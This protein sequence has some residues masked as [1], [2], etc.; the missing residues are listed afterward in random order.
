MTELTVCTVRLV[1]LYGMD[2]LLVGLS[3]IPTVAQI[4]ALYMCTFTVLSKVHTG[5]R[6]SNRTMV[7][8]HHITSNCA[9]LGALVMHP[10]EL[11]A[12]GPT[13]TLSWILS[14]ADDLH[15]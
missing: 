11:L 5:C 4:V 2:S 8:S 12:D 15:Y 10:G 14:W 3:T 1:T 9:G 7:M 13:M 6:D